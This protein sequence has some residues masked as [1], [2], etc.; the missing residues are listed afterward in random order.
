MLAYFDCFSGISGDMLLGALVDLGVP[1]AWLE[2]KLGE[3]PLDGFRLT[4]EVVNRGGMTAC[5]V[6]VVLDGYAPTR[7]F[8]D[9]QELIDNANLS[10]QV[11]RVSLEAFGRIAK[12]EAHVHR[13]GIEKVHFHEVGAVDALVDIIG[14]A[15]CLE[16]LGIACIVSS[17]L[18]LGSGFANCEHG[19]LALPSPAT[20]AILESAPVYG[21]G[22]S[23]ELVTPTGAAL[24]A[25]LAESYGPL[26]AMAVWKSGYGAGTRELETRPNVLR[27]ICGQAQHEKTFDADTVVVLE[28][29]IDD[30]SPEIYG[31]L[32]ERLFEDGALDVW[33]VPVH[34]KKN[35]PG[36]LIQILC[37][38]MDE[39]H[40]TARVFA[41]TTTL[42]IRHHEV[43]RSLLPR[44]AVKVA[45][46]FG[47]LTAKQIKNP[48][49]SIA[50]IPEYES[51][52]QM[53][54]ERDLPLK[55][56][57][58]QLARELA[59]DDGRKMRSDGGTDEKS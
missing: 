32:M 14:S 26:P 9:I 49:G 2:Q 31:H 5:K 40:I 52:R 51:C 20:L 27:I 24:V 22:I 29:C 48:D 46:S 35:R 56:V 38:R 33:W 30:M 11:K 42:G 36:T 7:N 41:E 12:A 55:Q 16:Y 44:M 50:L 8:A 6:C 43:Q 17:P 34:M 23:A 10:A 59:D 54:I 47:P 25:S 19:T 58:H 15:I 18:P 28:S 39:A 45:T 4:Q 21:G 13:C 53:A 57:Y 3:L 37:R 1:L